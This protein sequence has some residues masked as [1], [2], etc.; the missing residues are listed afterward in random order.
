MKS[1]KEKEVE[2]NAQSLFFFGELTG[3]PLWISCASVRVKS[4]SEGERVREA[5]QCP[6]GCGRD[7]DECVSV[8]GHSALPCCHL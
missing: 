5:A 8:M 2:T 4:S 7:G 6:P 1:F 3:I